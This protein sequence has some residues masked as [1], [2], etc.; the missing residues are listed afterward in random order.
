[1]ASLNYPVEVELGKSGEK[2]VEFGC[3]TISIRIDNSTRRNHRDIWI[4]YDFSD[5]DIVTDGIAIP[6]VK[7]ALRDVQFVFEVPGW[8]CQ[9]KRPDNLAAIDRT[10]E[11]REGELD[12]RQDAIKAGVPNLAAGGRKRKKSKRESVQDTRNAPY[13]YVKPVNGLK[14]RHGWKF[15]PKQGSRLDYSEPDYL[16]AGIMRKQEGEAEIVLKVEKFIHGHNVVVSKLAA[17]GSVRKMGFLGRVLA[18]LAKIDEHM[19]VR[20]CDAL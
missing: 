5:I 1:M 8:S 12:E 3:G 9:V 2:C 18:K 20:V 11:R 13:D 10:V 6:N 19:T 17:D 14:N 16:P 15:T 4:K 7:C